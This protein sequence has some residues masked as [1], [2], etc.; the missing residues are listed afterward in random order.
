MGGRGLLTFF[1]P[2]STSIYSRHKSVQRAP[3]YAG[4]I[5]APR[6]S[7]FIHCTPLITLK[8]YHTCI[9]LQFLF[10]FLFF[11][12]VSIDLGLLVE[13]VPFRAY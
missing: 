12:R 13:T 1:N 4:R 11:F 6:R 7:R 8:T 2:H 9:A 5:D 10:V 3:R